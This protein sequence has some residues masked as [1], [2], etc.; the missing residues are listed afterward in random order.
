MRSWLGLHGLADQSSSQASPIS[1]NTIYSMFFNT[2]S[3]PFT[4]ISTIFENISG[5]Y[6]FPD[7]LPPPRIPGT[8]QAVPPPPQVC[9]LRFL[10]ATAPVCISMRCSGNGHETVVLH[11]SSMHWRTLMSSTNGQANYRPD[12]C[13]A[14]SAI[15]GFASLR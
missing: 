10:A 14:Q 7:C 15:T 6:T 12:W 5:R 9:P 1:T 3:F 8:V 13:R 4:A 11:Q 2:F